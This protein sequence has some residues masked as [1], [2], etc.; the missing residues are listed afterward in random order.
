MCFVSQSTSW[1]IS[2]ILISDIT[3]FCLCTSSPTPLVSSAPTCTIKMLYFGWHQ[4]FASQEKNF[5]DKHTGCDWHPQ[6][7]VTLF[8]LGCVQG[9]FIILILMGQWQGSFCVHEPSQWVTRLHCNVVSHWLGACTQNDL[10]CVPKSAWDNH[11]LHQTILYIFLFMYFS[12]FMPVKMRCHNS[13]LI[14]HFNSLA[15]VIAIL[16][17]QLHNV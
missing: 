9:S 5:L 4:T 16:K 7:M 17:C 10:W 14:T 3:G 8:C 11:Q 12:H 15:L 13:Y 6:L 1:V 2:N